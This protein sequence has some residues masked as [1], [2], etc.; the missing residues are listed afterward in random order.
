MIR[1]KNQT[2]IDYQEDFD[3]FFQKI[4]AE[5]I[6]SSLRAASNAVEKGDTADSFNELLLRD[7]MD[8][9]IY[10]THQVQELS[11]KDPNISTLFITGCL[12][13]CMINSLSRLGTMSPEG[14]V[15]NDDGDDTVH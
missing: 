12:F 15:A 6:K 5:V 8:N 4:V 7:I 10:I 14:P 13:N 9:C 3:A 11:K 2:V 1:L